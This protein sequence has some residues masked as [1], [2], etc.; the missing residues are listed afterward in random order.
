MEWVSWM[1]R[2]NW[3]LLSLHWGQNDETWM[4]H[5]L[6]FLQMH[7]LRTIKKIIWLISTLLIFGC[8]CVE[9]T[10]ESGINTGTPSWQL[11]FTSFDVPVCLLFSVS[12]SPQGLVGF[13]LCSHE[14]R[15]NWVEFPF[16]Y[17]R[18]IHFQWLC[19]VCVDT[20]TGWVETGLSLWFPVFLHWPGADRLHF[21]VWPFT[22]SVSWHRNVSFWHFVEWFSVALQESDWGQDRNSFSLRLWITADQ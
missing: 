6:I 7:K 1:A 17:R 21:S 20:Q 14:S 8:K 3:V 13:S 5:M 10:Q 22:C 12:A 16:N 11:I 2:R 4:E 15:L 19:P 18:Q 9:V